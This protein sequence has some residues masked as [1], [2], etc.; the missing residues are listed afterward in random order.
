MALSISLLVEETDIY[1][2]VSTPFLTPWLSSIEHRK[3]SFDTSLVTDKRAST[4]G[5]RSRTIQT[6]IPSTFVIKMPLNI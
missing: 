6:S 5:E 3:A 2:G 4:C 1:P